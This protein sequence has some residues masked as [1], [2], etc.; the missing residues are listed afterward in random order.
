MLEGKAGASAGEEEEKDEDKE[1]GRGGQISP[2]DNPPLTLLFWKT[3]EHGTRLLAYFSC[4][5]V[6]DQVGLQGE[7]PWQNINSQKIHTHVGPQQ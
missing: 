2:L 4:R 6:E 3:N 1:E 7:Y 5:V